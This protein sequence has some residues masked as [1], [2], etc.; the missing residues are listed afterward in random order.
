MMRTIK[1]LFFVILSIVLISCSDDDDDFRFNKESLKQTIWEGKFI[2]TNDD[3][4]AIETKNVMF[5]FYTTEKGQYI[6]NEGG[7]EAVM[8]DF[9]YLIDDKMINIDNG[10]LLGNY[11]LLEFSKDKM[12]L[13]IPGTHKG[14]LTL[15]RKY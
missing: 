6:I 4:V 2:E 11:T 12:T 9:N 8:W 5:Q 7:H 15:N 3:E 14:T 10:S 13:V 1:L